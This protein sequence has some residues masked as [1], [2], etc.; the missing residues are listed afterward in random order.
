M[1]DGHVVKRSLLAVEA[2]IADGVADAA[3]QGQI[4]VVG[5]TA[6]VRCLDLIGQVADAALQLDGAVGRLGDE[7]E[8]HLADVGGLTV[9]VVEALQGDG[10]APGPFHELV[11]AS[12]DGGSARAVAHLGDILLIEDGGRQSGHQ[13]QQGGSGFKGAHP[14]GVFVDDLDTVGINGAPDVLGDG[15][16]ATLLHGEGDVVG[17]QFVAVVPLDALDHLEFIGGVVDELIL[18]QVRKDI[19]LLVG[20]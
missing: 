20:H 2:D 10:V 19:A 16:L 6:Q 11:R 3:E 1:T 9:I 5:N 12:A 4:R 7:S 18:R 14:Q 13:G 15:S 17:L 8:D